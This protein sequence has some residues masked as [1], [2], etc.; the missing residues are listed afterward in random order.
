MM[1]GREP[2]KIATGQ[3]L[4]VAGFPAIVIEA[5]YQ[6]GERSYAIVY[7]EMCHVTLKQVAL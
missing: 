2:H 4:Q 3:F 7:K 5:K 1:T 6:A